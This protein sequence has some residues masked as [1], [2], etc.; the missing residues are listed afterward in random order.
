MTS[1]SAAVK[2]PVF[3]IGGE[4]DHMVPAEVLRQ[5]AAQYQRADIVE[6]PGSDH[7]VFSG[8]SLPTTMGHIDDWLIKNQ[9]IP[10]ATN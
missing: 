2:T 5:T 8:A 4:C 9:L 10:A 1:D 3:V 6:M 7:M